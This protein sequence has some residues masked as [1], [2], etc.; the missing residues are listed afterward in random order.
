MCM[1]VCLLSL[2]W[3]GLRAYV[4]MGKDDFIPLTRQTMVDRCTVR[5]PPLH[6]SRQEYFTEVLVM[7]LCDGG[8][9]VWCMCAGLYWRVQVMDPLNNG[10]FVSI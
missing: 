9:C 6:D 4:C 10:I 7:C 5:N 2:R 1:Y 3:T 8:V